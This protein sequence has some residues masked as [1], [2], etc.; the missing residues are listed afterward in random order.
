[1]KFALAF[2]VC[3][4]LMACES[5]TPPAITVGSEEPTPIT[6]TFN[7]QS[8]YFPVEELKQGKIYEY[9][10]MQDSA[11]FVTHYW[12]LQTEVGAQGQTFLI[13]KRYNPFF[14]QDQYI[15]EW[16]VKDGVVTTA[17]E[18]FIKDSTAQNATRYVN[19]VEEN[20]VFPFEAA[21]DSNMVYRFSCALTLPPDFV[22]VRLIRDR[23][24]SQPLVYPYQGKKVP[25]VA[26][27]CTDLYDL[28]DKEEGGYWEQKTTSV[29][30]YAEGIGLVYTEQKN[31]EKIS[32]INQ[33]THIY[34]LEEFEILKNKIE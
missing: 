7:T 19:K 27:A 20:I 24:F 11:A 13:W 14:E 21:L 32:S 31:E 15:K 33:L 10:V 28:E 6:H 22:T 5:P 30:I 25:A 29:E 8:Y 18:M 3:L 23:Q 17:Y 12:H 16:I 34:T 9:S 1:M 2:W 26:F 4:C